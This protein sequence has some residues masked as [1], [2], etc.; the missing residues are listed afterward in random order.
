M[1]D[2]IL[3]IC[4]WGLA[5]IGLGLASGCGEAPDMYGSPYATFEIKGRVVDEDTG[6]PV[7]GVSLIRGYVSYQEGYGTIAKKYDP[8]PQ[9]RMQINDDGTFEINGST[10][11]D[12]IIP[13]YLSDDDPSE[14]GNYRDS[15]YVLELLP[16][17]DF[18]K[19]NDWH[20]GHFKAEDVM[21]KAKKTE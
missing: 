5:L 20:T 4:R 15:L 6:N 10:S 19:E 18:K 12:N 3:K 8:I 2:L 21:I 1:K 17:K 13:L 16:D 9:S 11:G 7:K 14:D